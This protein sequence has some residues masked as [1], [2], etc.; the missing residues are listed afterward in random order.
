[1]LPVVRCQQKD[2]ACRQINKLES[3]STAV[4]FTNTSDCTRVS[5]LLCCLWLQA[6][7]E[8]SASWEKEREQWQ[9]QA[10]DSISTISKLQELLAEGAS[11]EAVQDG[12]SSS[13]AVSGPESSAEHFNTAVQSGQNDVAALHASLLK[14]KA[15]CAQLDLQVRVLAAQLVRACAAYKSVGRSLLPMLSSVESKLVL[16]KGQT[17]LAV[18]RS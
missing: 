2:L 17:S 15:R 10:Q 11:W 1:M 18:A 5:Y 3:D 13:V 4:M 6:L 14:E 9:T 12:R 16:L 8:S 7:A